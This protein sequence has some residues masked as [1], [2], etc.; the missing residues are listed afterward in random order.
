[1]IG[2]MTFWEVS[3]TGVSV[4]WMDVKVVFLCEV[5]MSYGHKIRQHNPAKLHAWS[6][7]R[8]AEGAM[9]TPCG[10]PDRQ[11]KA[12]ECHHSPGLTMLTG[13]RDFQPEFTGRMTNVRRVL[14]AQ[15][16]RD[17]WAPV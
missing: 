12:K 14:R 13:S 10:S 6:R 17:R 9:Q 7:P 16:G 5:V 8:G 1:M 4:W 15:G 2:Y 3:V 11:E